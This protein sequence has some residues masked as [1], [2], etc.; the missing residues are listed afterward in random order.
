[1]IK[2]VRELAR[3]PLPGKHVILLDY[4]I[5]TMNPVATYALDTMSRVI[6]FTKLLN[7]N[8]F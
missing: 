1:V 2:L 3:L 5:N 6:S 8:I 4:H 7:Q